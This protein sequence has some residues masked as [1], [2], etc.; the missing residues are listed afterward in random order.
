MCLPTRGVQPEHLKIE[1]QPRTG[2][3]RSPA[4]AIQLQMPL[5][6]Q[7]GPGALCRP[8]AFPQGRR[9]APTHISHYR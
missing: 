7:P 4:L 9:Q 6:A 1:T 8:R 2:R 5:P 3:P